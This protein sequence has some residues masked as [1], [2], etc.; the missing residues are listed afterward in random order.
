MKKTIFGIAILAASIIGS[1]A[2]A[3]QVAQDNSSC[4]KQEQCQKSKDCKKGKKDGKR[5]H[6]EKAQ[7]KHGHGKKGQGFNPFEGIELTADQQSRID[8][9]RAEQKAKHEAQRAERK[10]EKAAAKQEARAQRE[11]QMN[12]FDAQVQTILTADQFQVYT[13]NRQALKAKKEAARQMTA[14][15]AQCGDSVACAQKVQCKGQRPVN[16]KAVYP[17]KK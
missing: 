14:Q 13:A 11:A 8:A 7:G 5:G 16:P 12:E 15:R 17:K 10:E 1:T 2:S 6:G 4:P 3:A 9:L